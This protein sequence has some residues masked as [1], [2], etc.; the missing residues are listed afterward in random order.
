MSPVHDAL[1]A[2]LGP[3]QGDRWLDLATGT[4]AVALRAARAGAEVT[5]LDLA[6]GLI[7]T[8]KR[9]ATERR[10][11][12]RFDTGD[13]ERLPYADA[14]FDVVS[15]A[16]GVVFAV[17]HAAVAAELARVCRPGGRLGLTYWLPNS[18][19]QR[20]MERVGYTRPD[21]AGRPA[22]WARR[23]YATGLLGEHFELDFA[24]AVCPWTGGVRRGA[25]AALPP[26]RRGRQGGHRRPVGRR[27]RGAQRRLGRVLRAP[28]QRSRRL[29]PAALRHHPGPMSRLTPAATAAPPSRPPASRSNAPSGSAS[30]PARSSRACP[31]SSGWRG[32]RD[33]A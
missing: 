27:A 1:V 17:D 4:G 5:G 33:R 28:P 3:R 23:D 26:C 20:L 31:T 12:V 24:E 11:T 13:V 8:A 25:L 30:A 29:R 9:L 16:H 2:R 22:D 6:P 21:G 19:L 10:L 15:S 7:E 18:E 32:G 14:S